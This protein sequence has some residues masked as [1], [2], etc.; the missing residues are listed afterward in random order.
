LFVVLKTFPFAEDGIRVK[1]MAVG[2]KA[3]F[4]SAT[5]GLVA[6]GLIAS[7]APEPAPVAA[8]VAPTVTERKPR[9]TR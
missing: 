9:K 8:P 7:T 2:D 1:H 4:G 6:E 5:N 3:D